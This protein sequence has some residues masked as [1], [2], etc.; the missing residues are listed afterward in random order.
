[1]MKDINRV[2]LSGLI[3]RHNVVIKGEEKI[4]NHISDG[5]IYQAKRLLKFIRLKE[6]IPKSLISSKY[7]PE[8]L[9]I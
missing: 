3:S 5:I 2:M 8:S 4:A 9:L 6:H 7:L 1:M